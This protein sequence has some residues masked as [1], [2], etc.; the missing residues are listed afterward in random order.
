MCPLPRQERLDR[1][2]RESMERKARQMGGRGGRGSGPRGRHSEDPYNRRGAPYG[3]RGGG[4]RG[5]DDDY[6]DRKRSGGGRGQGGGSGRANK[7]ARGTIDGLQCS[8]TERYFFER[9]KRTLDVGRGAW[10]EFVGCLG[11]YN[12]SVLEQ[13]DLLGMVGSLL[14]GHDELLDEFKVLVSFHST[15]QFCNQAWAQLPLS[16][17]D[18][19][20][21]LRCTPSYR[22]LPTAYP[23][24]TCSRRSEVEQGVL[25]DR[26]INMPM[27][28]E[29]NYAFKHMRKNQ[30][31]EELFKVEDQRF[32]MDMVIES[33]KAAIQKLQPLVEE[34][35]EMKQNASSAEGEGLGRYRF[36]LDERGL[37]TMHLDAISRVYGDHADDILSL[38]RKH[39]GGAIPVIHRRLE[40]K[41]VEWRKTRKQKVREWRPILEANFAKA[42]DH[43]RD[44][45][46]IRDKKLAQA[47]VLVTEVLDK[48]LEHIASASRDRKS[49]IA[50]ALLPGASAPIPV[51]TG[52][53]PTEKDCAAEIVSKARLVRGF[54]LEGSGEAAGGNFLVCAAPVI[55][56]L[57]EP[58]LGW[59]AYELLRVALGRNAAS[60][61][62]VNRIMALWREALIEFFD[63]PF[64]MLTHASSP[65]TAPEQAGE[66]AEAL[67]AAVGAARKNAAPVVNED[68]LEVGWQ[69]MSPNGRGKVVGVQPGGKCCLSVKGALGAEERTVE[70]EPAQVWPV[71]FR[72]QQ[73]PPARLPPERSSRGGTDGAAGSVSDAGG[74]AVA[75]GS[76]PSTPGPEYSE[77]L[78]RAP[79]LAP[80]N[81]MLVVGQSGLVALRLV[82]RLLERLAL[83]KELVEV[84]VQSTVD[85]AEEHPLKADV[86]EEQLDPEKA[87][88]DAVKTE[89]DGGNGPTATSG[90]MEDDPSPA[91][92]PSDPGNDDGNGGV[93]CD[94]YSLS[95]GGFAGFMGLLNLLVGG[96]LDA[97]KYEDACRSMC[98]SKAYLLSTMDKLC[99]SV[100]K[101]LQ[102]MVHDRSLGPLLELHRWEQS[103]SS[104]GDIVPKRYLLHAGELCGQTSLDLYRCQFDAATRTFTAEALGTPRAHIEPA[105]DA[106]AARTSASTPSAPASASVDPPSVEVTETLDDGVGADVSAAEGGP[107]TDR[108]AGDGIL[109]E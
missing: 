93:G 53:V 63:L 64:A 39:P 69:V 24:L 76:G 100:V 14:A 7:K 34:I 25:N 99:V 104:S 35:N 29:E 44:T 60:Q 92:G 82:A 86:R 6:F 26:W 40:Q 16:E 15:A 84:G 4:E 59:D 50:A 107:A 108:V 89:L 98:G 67:A 21:S 5:L 68:T 88:F 73:S 17:F 31:E 61:G 49:S 48:A 102:A 19:S 87:A 52:S 96:V 47:Q 42:L 33:N 94:V 85:G 75:G 30:Y 55:A 46:R 8:S 72:A 43:Q 51:P 103:S 95:K 18:L 78:G 65:S 66:C 56:A 10:G 91:S 22:A 58:T 23:K 11:L 38:L 36:R 62:D 74:S 57:P 9:V 45:F 12:S 81:R 105:V 90:A 37:S 54:D 1:A 3:G 13:A 83:A 20:A 109:A 2:A 28:S 41:D 32:E 77:P 101:A 80:S 79:A 106:P 70:W 97:S 27:G 71:T